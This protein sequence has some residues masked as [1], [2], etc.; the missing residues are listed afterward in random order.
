MSGS[1]T[2]PLPIIRFAL[3]LSALF[4]ALLA[5]VVACQSTRPADTART[6]PHDRRHMT[7]VELER[8]GDH[9]TVYVRQLRMFEQLA[10]H[11][12][13]DSLAHLYIAALDAP[14]SRGRE[15]LYA[16][17]CQLQKLDWQYGVAADKAI[18]RMSDSLFATP[19]I[20]R[21]WIQA[22]A[23]W[24]DSMDADYRCDLSKVPQAPDSL[25]YY[26]RRT[27]AP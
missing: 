12:P 25:T 13:T 22:Q 14:A 5:N 26:P 21:R 7:S 11:V 16:I 3:G 8:A 15:Y 20:R 1:R 27:A 6:R 4:T 17:T 9:D 19:E 10:T 2:A 24:P 23:R 18:E